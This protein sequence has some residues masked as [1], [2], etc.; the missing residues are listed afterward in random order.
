MKAL[1]KGIIIAIITVG[2][3]VPAGYL[4]FM[5]Y[6][7]ENI[8]M[9]NLIPQNSTLVIRTDYNGTPLYLYNSSNTDGV[10][11][12]LSL[13]N[14]DAELAA[15]T[16][17]TNGTSPII[18]PALYTTYREYSI[19][20]ISNV[21]LEG[22]IPQNL[23][24]LTMGYNLSTNISKYVSNN[25]IYVAE[26]SGV[27]SLGSIEAVKNSIDALVDNVNFAP[28]A[29][30]YFNLTANVS[31]YYVSTNMF[32][33]QAISNVYYLKSDF[34]LQLNNATTAQTINRGLSGLNAI[35]S[36]YTYVTALKM[37]GTWVNG[38][39][40]VGIGNYQML[41]YLL[42]DL[43]LNYSKYLLGPNL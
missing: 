32:V 17:Q 26:V 16:N 37:D 31:V 27:V 8:S 11:V 1:L 14:F 20:Q 10:V 43:N 30:K 35:S 33:R 23:S 42:Q 19:Y 41:E 28:V 9:T 29:A 25:T 22:L 13:T 36:N 3:V 6:H 4:S 15:S 2:V 12:G 24:S 40:A 7:S 34:S 39:M 5:V 21:S 38:T 18:Q